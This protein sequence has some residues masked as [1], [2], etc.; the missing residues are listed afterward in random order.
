MVHKQ[1]RTFL[2]NMAMTWI[3]QK[4]G[5][6]LKL[7]FKLPKGKYK[8]DFVRKHYIRAAKAQLVTEIPDSDA[9]LQPSFPL[10]VSNSSFQSLESQDMGSLKSEKV[11]NKATV[12]LKACSVTQD[13]GGTLS[14]DL[15]EDKAAVSC[16]QE[17]LQ[18]SNMA[19]EEGASTF[20]ATVPCEEKRKCKLGS[21]ILP[22]DDEM[23]PTQLIAKQQ[24]LI[25][26]KYIGCPVEL[27]ILCLSFPSCIE[28]QG[29]K[30]RVSNTE[31]YVEASSY[32]PIVVPLVFPTAPTEAKASFFHLESLL[33]VHLPYLPFTELLT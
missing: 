32:D 14:P 20:L 5:L 25:R 16:H 17:V 21:C 28:L 24:P 23:L 8:G 7:D 18:E 13:S 11:Y 6:E 22:Q 30:V 31:L 26:V 15:I 29:L 2:I 27:V 12:G 3:S 19:M 9:G 10:L 1:L 33:E 4:Y